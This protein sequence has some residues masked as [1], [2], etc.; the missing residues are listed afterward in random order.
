MF[1]LACGEVQKL[2]VPHGIMA[3][4]AGVCEIAADTPIAGQDWLAREPV[5]G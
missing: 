3:S 4:M 1:R 5:W 2:V